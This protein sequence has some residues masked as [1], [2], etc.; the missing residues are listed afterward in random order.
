MAIQ[1]ETAIRGLATEYAY[2]SSEHDK[3]SLVGNQQEIAEAMKKQVQTRLEVCGVEILESRIS[4][5]SYS[6]KLRRQCLEDNK[7]KLLLRKNKNC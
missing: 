1:S 5:L 3:F 2:D 4:H 6:R 7:L